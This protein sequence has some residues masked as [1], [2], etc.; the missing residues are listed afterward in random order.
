M[1]KKK[2]KIFGKV[3]AL[4]VIVVAIFFSGYLF[5]DKLIVPKYFGSYGIYN[6][7]DLVGVV[8]SLYKNPNESKF[9]TNG[10]DNIDLDSAID[11]LQNANYKVND[12]GKIE[13][14]YFENIKGDQAIHLTDK[15]FASIVN[16]FLQDETGILV[17]E[18]P[19][20]NYLN[21]MNIS[22]LEVIITP[23]KN[24][25]VDGSENLYNA[26]NI[27]FVA[28]IETIDIREQIAEQMQTPIF[29]LNMIIPDVL[30]FEVSYDFDLSEQETNRV[31]NGS[32]S[33]NDRTSEQSEILI[34]LLIEFIFPEEEQMNLQKFTTTFGDIILQGIDL[35]GEFKFA[36]KL[37]KLQK[38][39]GIYINPV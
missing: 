31:K 19:N 6:V 22:I 8:T 23:N 36:D 39:N 26:A 33:I 21:A 27:S 5:L 10:H 25:L 20:L 24:S 13:E 4:F 16:K 1:K 11:V 15:Q 37:G 17:S 29:L 12:E 35:L 38:Q 34:N 2:T 28:K 30:Y 7:P 3:F 14:Q 32:I 9:I 18:L